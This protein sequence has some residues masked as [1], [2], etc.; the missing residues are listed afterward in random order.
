MVAR[1]LSKNT[2]TVARKEYKTRVRQR[3]S[4]W[5]VD[6]VRKDLYMKLAVT[7][8]SEWVKLTRPLV[9]RL[10]PE[11]ADDWKAR[12]AAHGIHVSAAECTHLQT[13]ITTEQVRRADRRSSSASAFCV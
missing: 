2:R 7:S 13:P 8:G 6:K 4:L 10:D 9:G 1:S 3:D 12:M 5:Y 11:Q